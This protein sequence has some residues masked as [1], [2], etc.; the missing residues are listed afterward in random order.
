VKYN[1]FNKP[2]K[3]TQAEIRDAQLKIL[4]PTKTYNITYGADDQRIQ[5]QSCITYAPQQTTTYTDD[6]EEVFNNITGG[7]QLIHYLRGAIFTQWYD[8]SGTKVGTDSLMYTY[9]DHQGSLIALVTDS[10]SGDG[11]IERYAYDP[12]GRRRNP[13]D[14]TEYD[15][16]TKWITHRGYTGHEH[17]DFMSGLIN[18]NG[19]VYDPVTA[20]FLS[21]DNN[22]QAP[23]SWV[24][25]NRYAYCMNNPLKYTD[26]SGW[27]YDPYTPYWYAPNPTGTPPPPP[28][29]PTAADFYCNLN[30]TIFTPYNLSKLRTG[31]YRFDAYG[32]LNQTAT[33]AQT[34]D[35]AKQAIANAIRGLNKDGYHVQVLSPGGNFKDGIVAFKGASAGLYYGEGGGI[36]QQNPTTQVYNSLYSLVGPT[37][38]SPPAGGAGQGSGAGSGLEYNAKVDNFMGAISVPVGTFET[39]VSYVA[40]AGKG[41]SRTANVVGHTSS[42]LGMLSIGYDFATGT[43]N[44]STVMNA[45]VMVG[46]FATVAIVGAAAAPWVAGIGVVYGIAS[47][48]FETPLNN[49]LD[50]SGSINFVQKKQP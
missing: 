7:Y 26:P 43:A 30:N 19:R 35:A 1:T 20:Q 45:A 50:I 25:Y 11:G 39:A 36:L 6:Y 18:M 12:W 2:T 31:T 47:F 33:A 49:A 29:M 4:S 23:D 41:F 16:R 5:T 14:W 42:A 46:G 13:A 8:K 3:I 22:I 34:I 38:W 24:N 37:I 27:Q 28:A 21:V 17:I 44:T 32:F 15:K 40:A 10:P 48:A 9:H